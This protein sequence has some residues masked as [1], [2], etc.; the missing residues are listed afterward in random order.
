MIY[1]F[2]NG[3]KVDFSN[4]YH[5]TAISSKDIVEQEAVISGAAEKMNDIRRSGMLSGH[6]SKDG[7]L[8]R[9][10]FPTLVRP[11]GRRM[12][13]LLRMAEMGKDKYDTAV[14]F[15]IGGS[16]LGNQVLFD[17]F[18]G[19]YWNQKSKRERKGC[20]RLYFS[21]NNLDFE[22]WSNGGYNGAF[23]C[24]TRSFRSCKY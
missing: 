4:I 23:F 11:D 7:A 10:L 15:G 5:E 17:L 3:F 14:S 16:Y 19:P 21:G 18:C 9:V 24:G 2:K 22:I 13:R 6:V 20:P 1:E 12:E 8:E